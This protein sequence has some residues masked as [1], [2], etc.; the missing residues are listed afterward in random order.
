MKTR[1]ILAI[2]LG[3]GCAASLPSWADGSLDAATLARVDAAIVFC[4]QLNPAGEPAYSALRASVIGKRSGAV[5]EALTR[6]PEYREALEAGGKTLA[7]EPQEAALKGCTD[8]VPVNKHRDAKA[9]K[10]P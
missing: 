7:E 4:R 2:G 5:V 1:I 9:P 10:H 3:L 6:T 8:L